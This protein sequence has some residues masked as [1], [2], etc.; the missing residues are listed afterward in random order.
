[1]SSALN[2]L[3]GVLGRPDNLIWLDP[4]V[5]QIPVGENPRDEDLA[6]DD[7][8]PLIASQGF[9]IDHPISVYKDDTNRFQ[10][11]DG[12]RRL[13]SVWRLI[14][15]GHDFPRIPAIV[16]P[17]MADPAERLLCALAGNQGKRLL[18]T[19]EARAFQRFLNMGWTVEQIA[20]RSGHP[21]RYV[22]ERLTLLDATP[23]VLEAK[24]QG[25]ISWTDVHEIVRTAEREM[26]PQAV[27]LEAT[28]AAKETR[29]A[30]KKEQH[31]PQLTTPEAAIRKALAPL[32]DL[33]GY[34]RIRTV[35]D[36]LDEAESQSAVA[37]LGA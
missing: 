19:E 20:Q 10:L 17:R 12:Q 36:A 9:R 1:M 18:P 32:F 7:L 26:V 3:E 34:D 11:I 23:A 15:E 35:L 31:T 25:D 28:R 16:L 6:L 29:K 5:I 8:M 27:A 13:R 24:K 21:A 33:Y 14:D 2:K 22:R 37:T 4:R 30:A